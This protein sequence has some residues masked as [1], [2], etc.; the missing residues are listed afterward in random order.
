MRNFFESKTPW[1]KNDG[2]LHLYVVPEDEAFLDRVGQAQSRLEGIP[3]LPPMPRAYLHCTVQRLAHFDDEVAQAELSVLGA[4][5]N[6][7][8]AALSPFELRFS[9]PQV[10]PHAVEYVAQPDP[11]WDA[12]VATVRDGAVA[13]WGGELPAAPYGPHLTLSYATADVPDETVAEAL[14]NVPSPGSLRVDK[15][16]LVSVTVRP[17]IGIFDFTTLA[18]WDLSG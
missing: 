11:A 7:R 16:A 14:L 8:F 18:D 15:V 3:Q 10:R 1:R 12:M 2:A 17:E 4:E 6:E 9:A 13:A 5:L